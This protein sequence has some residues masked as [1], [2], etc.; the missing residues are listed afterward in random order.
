[1]M[2][3]CR[4]GGQSQ[5]SKKKTETRGE[6]AGSFLRLIQGKSAYTAN[7]SAQDCRLLK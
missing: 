2:L 3:I 6:V 7:I 1:M 4:R 5:F